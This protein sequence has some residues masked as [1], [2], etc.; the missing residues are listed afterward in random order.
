VIPA[1]IGDLLF[2]PA[3]SVSDLTYLRIVNV[4]V[5]AATA[6][7]LALIVYKLI[8]KDSK[9]YGLIAGCLI[10]LTVF[11]V[12]ASPNAATWAVQSTLHIAMPLA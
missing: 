2:S 3:R 8:S 7:V 10:G 1:V 11:V 5:L 6:S 4:V 12:P 9:N